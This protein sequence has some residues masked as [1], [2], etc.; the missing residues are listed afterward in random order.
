M[1]GLAFKAPP[2]LTL[3]LSPSKCSK[4]GK[5]ETLGRSSG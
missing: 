4:M 3:S 5:A 2:P 1:R